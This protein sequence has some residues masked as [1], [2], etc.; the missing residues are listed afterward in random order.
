MS[1]SATFDFDSSE[2]YRAS[3]E[4]ARRISTRWLARAFALLALIFVGLNVRATWGSPPAYVFVNALPWLLLGVFW[5]SLVPL[6]QWWAAKR[7]PAR[8]ASVRGTQERTVDSQGYH[9]RGN[10]VALDI[11]WHAMVR[12]VETDAFFLF[13]YNKQ[14]A[15]YLP[16]RA[17]TDDQTRQVRG[18]ARDGLGDRVELQAH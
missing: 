16:K 6:T 18:F 14:C 13:F 7:L 3:R 17:L 8:D 2:H 12:V 1:V 5:L 9:S 11:P 4:V 10:N 15:Y